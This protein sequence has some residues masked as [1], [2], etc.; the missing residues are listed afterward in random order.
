MAELRRDPIT[1]EWVN[2][3][4]ERGKRPSDFHRGGRARIVGLIG[5]SRCPFCP[6]NEERTGAEVLRYA[7]GRDWSVRVVANKLSA[8]TDCGAA[9]RS[10]CGI[11]E[12]MPAVGTHEIVIETPDHCRNLSRLG[13]AEVKQVLDAYRERYL[14]LRK[15]PRIKYVL[16][17]RNYGKI[18]GA[19]IEHAHLQIVGTAII[20]P[21]ARVKIAGV[22]RYEEEYGSFVYCDMVEEEMWGGDRLVAQN[23]SF[24]ALTP[25]ASRHPFETWIIPLERDAHFTGIGETRMADL[26]AILEETLLR[27]DLCLGD[28]AYNFLLLTTDLSDG[29]NWHIEIVPRLNVA[30]GFE[31]GTG[32]HV[33]PVA[34]EDAAGFLREVI[35]ETRELTI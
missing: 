10:Q 3:A 17:F 28:P 7:K 2:I 29:P 14:A 5:H 8:F 27:L 31:L 35:L 13:V 24:L 19:S 23:A 16:I 26:A 6:G 12:R 34:P 33:N 9:A 1:R 20:P 25:Y 22:Q 18:A 4:T 32:I 30:A 15:N 21:A 11:Y